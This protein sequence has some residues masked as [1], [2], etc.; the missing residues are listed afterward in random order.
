M[1]KSFNIFLLAALV[2]LAADK[3]FGYALSGPL[4]TSA[5]GEPWQV[6]T[7]GYAL[8]NEQS[9]Q[10]GSPTFYQDIAGPHNIGEEYR[11]N[12]PFMYYAYDANFLGFFGLAGATNCDAAFSVFNALTNVSTYSAALNEFPP[13][14]QDLNPAASA[15]YLTDLKSTTMHLIVE[16]LGLIQPERFTWTLHDRFVPPGCPLTTTYLVVQR[17]FDVLD[18]PLNQIQYSPYVNDV[19]Y[20]YYITEICS[21]PNPP[22]KA[23]T[24]PFATDPTAWQYSSVAANDYNIYPDPYNLPLGNYGLRIG[25]YYTGLTK[26]D[27]AGLRYLLNSNNINFE[28]T[29]PSGALLLATNVQTPVNITT[30]PFSLLFSQSAT[31]DPDTLRTNY[32][33]ITFLSVITN[34]APLITTNITA[35]FTNLAGPYTNHVPL[36]NNVAIYP[37]QGNTVPFTNWS[38]IQYGDP[39]VLVNTRSLTLLLY[40]SQFLDP[41]SLQALYPD[42]MTDKVITN[43]LAI[44]IQTNRDIY[45]TNLSVLPT[46]NL[47]TNGLPYA[48]T[49]TN[50][51]LFTNQPGTT[52]I[53]Y[54]FTQP[55]TTISTLDL[56]LFSDRS[57]TNDAA[58]MQA[59]YP[60]L[61]ISS[62]ISVPTFIWVTNYIS[63]LTNYPGTP[64][65][66]P[67]RIVTLAIST[68][69]E[70][71]TRW[72]HN[73]ANVFTNHV[74]T[75]RPYRITS[76]WST[77][78]PNAPYGSPFIT[79]TNT[80]VLTTNMISGDF[81][82]VPTNWC[83]FDLRLTTPLGNPAHSFSSTNAIG[84]GYYTNLAVG[85]TPFS[86]TNY[87]LSQ[88]TNYNYAV[89][90][91][92]CNPVV[93]FST[94]FS[95][96]AIYRYQYNFLNV[97]TNHYY[98]NSA[99]SVLITNIEAIPYTNFYAMRT[100]ISNTTNYLNLPGGDFYLIPSNWCG[101]QI[102]ALLTNQIIPTNIVL[103]NRSFGNGNGASTITNI[104]YTE[105][106]YLTFTNYSYSIRPGFCEPALAFTTNYSTNLVTQYQYYFGNIVTN[107]F[108][109]NALNRVVT[110]NL[111]ILTNGLVG[112]LT[113]IVTT[114]FVPAGIEG[115][116]LPIP[117]AWCDYTRLATQSIGVIFSTNVFTATNLATPDLGEQFTQTT[118]HGYTNMTVLVQPSICDTV[119]AVPALRQGIERVQ[120]IRANFDSLVGQFFQPITNRYTMVM[121][122]NSQMKTEFYQRVVTRPDILFSARDLADGP[123][124]ITFDLPLTR[125]IGFDTSQVLN[126][127]RG[128][129]TI[130]SPSTFTFSKVGSIF[131]NGP[132]SDT[133]SYISSTVSELTQL[134]LLQWASFDS[135]TNLPILYP[136]GS[137]IL[138]L[139]NMIFVQVLPVTLP[140]GN[141]GAAYNGGLG[142]TLTATGGQ[143]PYVWSAPNLPTLV[144]GMSFN[145]ATQK[146]SGT[147][148][149]VGVFHF[150]IQVT[151]SVNRVVNIDYPITI[152]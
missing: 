46:F 4:P 96:N 119:P 72:V 37:A 123:A 122:T 65:Q 120:F 7:I 36:S 116:F 54:D 20:S 128:P 50:I 49:L 17:N 58:T 48:T 127:L 143:P 39:P 5:G 141:V 12:T 10:L 90:P 77:N 142:V 29:A 69:S 121:I 35:Y 129:G 144:P 9:G 135:S 115:D 152:K 1:R 117:P 2:T 146:L 106:Q 150:T 108:Y 47:L 8:G 52:V 134:K 79:V 93:Q 23:V 41:A 40:L 107:R 84:F 31:N 113:N 105:V 145:P 130:V 76:I 11:R 89:Y 91:G 18:T 137:S 95:T 62:S 148:T 19:L 45:F 51:Y 42:L 33:G 15:L 3:A 111:A 63:Y 71:V 82:L 110:T 16:Q 59:L 85:N 139:A 140:D 78:I 99:V 66:G 92:I 57:A 6:I 60:G 88:F 98:S 133:N 13:N 125:T 14:S 136:N 151:D 80:K 104:Q 25:G 102:V 73:F 101:Y 109:T 34:I 28:A 124:G 100:N 118:V 70:F 68:N 131:E 112:Q 67:P 53:N 75:N 56:G 27:V 132:F 32:P 147:P 103:T 126:G 61:V 94:N 21:I 44:D 87:Y 24:H 64:Y 138:N 26:D 38:P 22:T 97:V 83:G 74:F 149:S 30:L 43:F 81:F 86:L 55:P 114:N